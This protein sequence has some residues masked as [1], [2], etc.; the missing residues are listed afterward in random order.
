M[1]FQIIQHECKNCGCMEAEVIP[2]E[3]GIGLM[4]TECM[5]IEKLNDVKVP[6]KTIPLCPRCNS[7]SIT[8]IMKGYYLWG[9][10]PHN[11]CQSCGYTW[12]PR[13]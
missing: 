1:S 9:G 7:T 13:P 6:L 3:F 5:E 2:T 11:Y 12:K 4:C 10:T 8:T